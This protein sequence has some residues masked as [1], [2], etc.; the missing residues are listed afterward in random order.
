MESSPLYSKV[1]LC[2]QQPK[3]LE[4]ALKILRGECSVLEVAERLGQEEG[5]VF[6]G[7]G[8]ALMLCYKAGEREKLSQKEAAFMLGENINTVFS[9]TLIPAIGASSVPLE[10]IVSHCNLSTETVIKLAKALE[11][12]G[13]LVGFNVSG[14]PGNCEIGN[15]ALKYACIRT[16]APINWFQ[17]ATLDDDIAESR[18]NYLESVSEVRPMKMRAKRHERWDSEDSASS[19]STS[20]ISAPIDVGS[21]PKD[22]RMHSVGR[23]QRSKTEPTMHPVD[24][25]HS[26]RISHSYKTKPS[27]ALVQEYGR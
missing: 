24:K 4:Y 20:A 2:P 8:D 14:N 23:F 7:D 9:K 27:A 18:E 5:F 3:E 10:L 16:R 6:D 1:T 26:T 12:N 13:S 22:R 11:T 19:S 25:G 17:G 21:K 15:V